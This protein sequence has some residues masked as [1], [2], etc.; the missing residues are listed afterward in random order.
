MLAAMQEAVAAHPA[1]RSTVAVTPCGCLGPCF[2][3][4]T[5]VVYPEGVWYAGVTVAEVPELVERHL[6][7]GLPMDRLRL[8]RPVD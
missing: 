5:L 2:D 8:E 7:E 6:V 3:G 1:L 4:P